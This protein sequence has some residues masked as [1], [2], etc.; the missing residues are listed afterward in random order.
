MICFCNGFISDKK[1]GINDLLT[2]EDALVNATF[3]AE[4]LGAEASGH[5]LSQGMARMGLNLQQFFFQ[6]DASHMDG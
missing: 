6:T 5:N 2:V 4:A 3:A 1:K